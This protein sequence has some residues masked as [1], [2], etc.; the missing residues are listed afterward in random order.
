MALAPAVRKHPEARHPTTGG[1]MPMQL[2]ML[3]EWRGVEGVR[4]LLIG[5]ARSAKGGV[6]TGTAG[7]SFTFRAFPLACV[8][9][10]G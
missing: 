10:R 7:V 4:D 6:A 8:R 3:E 9:K 5:M 1:R 2:S